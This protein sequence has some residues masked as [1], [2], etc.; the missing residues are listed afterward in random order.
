MARHERGSVTAGRHLLF[1]AAVPIAYVITGR[2][3]LLLAVPPGY[4]TAVF[5]P[6]GIAVAAMFMAGAATLPGTFLGS[7]LLN[8]WIGYSLAQRLDRAG[9]AAALVI[10]FASTLQ[11]G[12]GGAVLRVVIGYPAPLDT[13][14]ELLRFLLLSAAVCV[15]SATLSLAGMWALGVVAAADLPINWM[16]WWVGD[17]LGVI[18]ALP[19][20]LVIAGEPRP[21]WRSRIRF[22]AVPMILCFALF[23][24]IFVRVSKWE[25]EQSLLEF[26]MKSQ[27]V[28]EAIKAAM[29]E[30]ALFLEQLAG[31]IA[32]RN[33]ALTRQNFHGLVQ[34]LLQRFPTIQAVE[35]APRVAADERQAF[36][37]ASGPPRRALPFAN[38]MRQARCGQP[39]TASNSFP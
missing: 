18:V 30:Q 25:N 31:V 20:M 38:V 14:R 2:L 22:V 10:A 8:T 35:W 27:H 24:A 13:L 23:V 32:N 29:D 28:A 37:A 33:S 17:A 15:T 36:E 11:A 16:T 19:L 39:A 26:R 3:G 1:Y 21:L 34:S 5:L 7:F 6:A 9:L 12:I 4:A